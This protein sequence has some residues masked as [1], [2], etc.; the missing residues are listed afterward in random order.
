[1][2]REHVLERRV[3]SPQNFNF[4]FSKFSLAAIA[5]AA[6]KTTITTTKTR[7]DLANKL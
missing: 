6:A 5:L 3:A 7:R 2:Q 4:L 1:M